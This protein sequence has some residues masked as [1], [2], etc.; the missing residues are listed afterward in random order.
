M[1]LRAPV[2]RALPVRRELA[3]RVAPA[4]VAVAVALADPA[5]SAADLAVPACP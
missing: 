5:G 1:T 4:A 3:A 2:H